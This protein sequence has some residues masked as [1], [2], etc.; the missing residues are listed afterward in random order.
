MKIINAGLTKLAVLMTVIFAPLAFSAQQK[1]EEML[2]WEEFCEQLKLSGSELLSKHPQDHEIDRAEG[3]IYLTQRLARSVED[4]LAKDNKSFPLL[5]LG[6]TFIEK[7]G[8][9][10]ADA[11]Y[12]T[13]DIDG[14][15][16]YR[17][18]GKLGNARLIA[19]QLTK[20]NP[21]YE[22]YAS[23][24]DEDMGADENGHID[25]LIAEH[26]PDDW[27][28]AWLPMN[29]QSSTL[30]LREYFNDW[31]SEHPSDL[32]LQRVDQVP[33][34]PSPTISS[35]AVTLDNVSEHFSNQI[36][37]W[38]S[39]AEFAKKNLVNRLDRGLSNDNQA[40]ENNI[41]GK[42]WFKLLPQQALVIELAEPDAALWSFQLADY[43]WQS[44]DYVSR[45]GSINGHQA[46]ADSDGKYRLVISHQDPG[47]PNWLD[48]G[49]H[50]E[51]MIMYRYQ[52]STNAPEPKVTLVTIDQ[53][54]GFLPADSAKIDAQGRV[55]QV[56]ARRQHAHRRWA[57]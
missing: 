56:T 50:P 14:S 17:L 52:N 43:W 44:L 36:E 53:L 39:S 5:R 8:L 22:A 2:A 35:V 9:D 51:G 54:P 29:P 24:S 26:K 10:G 6:T 42:G 55:S 31:D 4:V 30:W 37:M 32:I 25:I 45:T 46:V 1:S 18:S 3:L 13:A 15:G 48:P 28:G 27:Q 16:V 41:Y 20:M 23:L 7:A 33:A 21:V 40:L 49:G 12:V 47:V 19:I 11:K 34:E 38:I 57:P